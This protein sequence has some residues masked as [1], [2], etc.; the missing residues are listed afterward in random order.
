MR[1]ASLPGP[2]R[3]SLPKL[4]PDRQRSALSRA[5]LAI[6]A[7]GA[8]EAGKLGFMAGL[9]VQATLPHRKLQGSSFDR[10]NG[11]LRL[12]IY[13]HPSIGLPYGRYPRLLLAWACTQAVR[14]RNPVLEL[15]SSLSGFMAQLGLM[16]TGGH[17][18]TIHRLRDQMKRLFSATI[19]CTFDA[20]EEGPWRDVGFRLADDVR[21]WWN[22]RDPG[23]FA[24]AGSTIELSERFFQ[25]VVQRPVPVDLRA[26]QALR[27]PLALDI[28][29]WLTHRSSYLR[30]PTEIRWEGLQLQFGTGYARTRAFKQAFL[31]Q[32]RKVLSLY[33]QARI[34]Q[35]PDGL[36]LRP[37]P[38]HVRRLST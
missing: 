9:L 21:L 32:A 4:A 19:C 6:E 17:W 25:S 24:E 22:P 15:G 34:E 31:L 3:L 33:P 26:L 2:F 28:Y 30:R 8:L 23:Q 14:T 29:V 38:P 1:E 16:P 37:A 18:G 11:A 10:K 13:A 5:A 36:L 7:R 20:S 35:T 27:S 12:S